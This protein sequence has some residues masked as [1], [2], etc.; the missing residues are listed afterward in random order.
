MLNENLKETFELDEL[1]DF[2]ANEDITY[3][4][5]ALGY[6][7]YDTVSGCDVFLKEFKDP[8]EAITFAKAVDLGLIIQRVAERKLDLT[9][10]SYFNLE[11]ET[12]V[13]CEDGTENIDTVW[14]TQI[15]ID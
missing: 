7:E 13:N 5:C 9:T 8:G 14:E 10:T 3:L 15:S 4:V 12:V 1:E 2:E 11:V 6:T